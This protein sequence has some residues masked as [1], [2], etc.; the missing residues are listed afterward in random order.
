MRINKL[1]NT[2]KKEESAFNYNIE[3]E[4]NNELTP[5]TWKNKEI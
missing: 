2:L 4:I 3:L 5:T 1:L